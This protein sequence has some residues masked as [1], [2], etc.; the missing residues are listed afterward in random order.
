[1]SARIVYSG[2]FSGPTTINVSV[3]YDYA[4][5][6]VFPNMS[7][8][9]DKHSSST[10]DYGYVIIPGSTTVVCKGCSGNICLLKLYESNSIQPSVNV[11][12]ASAAASS[13]SIN[14]SARWD[15]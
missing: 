5:V 9:Y 11:G 4:E 8:A 15:S 7:K 3:D 14:F 1:M 2:G 6:V 10:T 12:T 13:L